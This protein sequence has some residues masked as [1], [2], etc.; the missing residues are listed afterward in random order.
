M[1]SSVFETGLA[2][3]CLT[4]GIDS[5]V[6]GSAVIGPV[7]SWNIGG[8]PIANSGYRC[9]NGA[10]GAGEEFAMSSFGC[11]RSGGGSFALTGTGA[12]SGSFGRRRSGGGS[13]AFTGTGAGGGSFD[14]TGAG[15]G[16]FAFTGNGGF[17]TCGVA[18]PSR[19]RGKG[20]VVLR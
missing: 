5:A 4:L 9:V 2:G 17:G 13:F 1:R 10:G 7:G 19:Q 15:G 8:Y 6:I 20:S 3:R 14:G 11:G 12:G 16:S 18:M